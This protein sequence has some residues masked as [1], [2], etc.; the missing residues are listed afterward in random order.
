MA[1]A[2]KS[3]AAQNFGDYQYLDESGNLTK[4]NYVSYEEG[5]YVGYRYYETRYEDAVLGQGNAGGFT[6]ADEVCYPFGFGLSYTTFDWTN[7]STSWSGKT[8]TAKV[9][10]ANTGDV[11]G[12][13]VV[14][15]YAQS[16]YTDYDRANGQDRCSRQRVPGRHLRTRQRRRRRDHLRQR[17]PH[18][19]GRCQP[20]LRRPRRR[21][22]PHPRGLGEHLPHARR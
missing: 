5:I 15:L 10:V 8:C 3:P 12:K 11:A 22:L 19:R 7:F 16:P 1:D 6:Y 13:D 4:Y 2:S 14:E 17:H 20:P 9:T 21:N 18:R